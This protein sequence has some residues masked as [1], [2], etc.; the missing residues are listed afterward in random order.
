[1]EVV[2]RVFDVA[3]PILDS[4]SFYFKRLRKPTGDN[5]NSLIKHVCGVI[6]ANS[7]LIHCSEL[8]DNRRER[9]RDDKVDVY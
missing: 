7:M 4:L 2:N 1:M 9:E 8:N 3:I 5:E 6:F